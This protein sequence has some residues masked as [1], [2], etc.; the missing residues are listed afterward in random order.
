MLFESFVNSER[1]KTTGLRRDNRLGLRALL[2]QKDVKLFSRPLRVGAGLRALLIQKDVKQ[3]IPY[4]A[5]QFC[6]RALLIQKDVKLAC[7][8]IN[9]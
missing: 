8:W 4:F 6:L 3:P 7:S 9:S 2:I 1:C 5:R